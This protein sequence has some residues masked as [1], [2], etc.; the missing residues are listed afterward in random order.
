MTDVMRGLS[1]R[2]IAAHRG[3]SPSTIANQIA[4]AYSKLGIGSRAELAARFL[5]AAAQP[6]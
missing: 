5:G 1:N 4:S 3:R 2:A 6:R